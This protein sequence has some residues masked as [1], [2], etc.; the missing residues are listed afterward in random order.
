[1]NVR[2]F[3]LSGEQAIALPPNRNGRSVGLTC[4][5]PAVVHWILY[6]AFFHLYSRQ[7]SPISDYPHLAAFC[8][9]RLLGLYWLKPK[10][11]NT[12]SP[13]NASI[14][15]SPFYPFT[16]GTMRLIYSLQLHCMHTK[17]FTVSIKRAVETPSKTNSHHQRH[18]FTG[19]MFR[20]AVA[21]KASQRLPLNNIECV[22]FIN[23]FEN[24]E[25]PN[26]NSN[27]PPNENW[28]STVGERART[29][30]GKS[31]SMSGAWLWLQI[32]QFHQRYM[33]SLAIW[34]GRP[35]FQTTVQLSMYG[36]CIRQQHFL[37]TTHNCECMTIKCSIV[38]YHYSKSFGVTNMSRAYC[39]AYQ[40]YKAKQKKS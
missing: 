29:V 20:C 35:P 18:V 34:K 37:R 21:T 15:P 9:S 7:A 38:L 2:T 23:I 12:K 6:P 22:A 8:P 3:H 13:K 5:T 11:S 14:V 25:T 28:K 27:L 1:M 39:T 33:R 10:T 32:T 4:S 30:R 17:R 40:R 16:E 19:F 24:E 31:A 36:C 26:W